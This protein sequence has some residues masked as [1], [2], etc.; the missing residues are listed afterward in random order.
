METVKAGK[1]ETVQLG[2]QTGTDSPP[3][4]SSAPSYYFVRILPNLSQ[5]DDKWKFVDAVD[6]RPTKI[7]MILQGDKDY[8]HAVVPN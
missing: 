8:T 1:A 4:S 5:W 2:T 3:N 7:S 6:G